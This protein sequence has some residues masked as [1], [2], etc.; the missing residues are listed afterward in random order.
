MKK[1]KKRGGRLIA[2]LVL[3][4]RQTPRRSPQ[5]SKP[6]PGKLGFPQGTGWERRGGGARQKVR[7]PR[8]SGSQSPGRFRREGRGR[9][10]PSGRAQGR[11]LPEH[12]QGR[13][14][15]LPMRSRCG[16]SEAGGRARA[17]PPRWQLREPG[18]GAA[19]GAAAA[20]A[21]RSAR[22]ALRPGPPGWEPRRKL[23]TFLAGKLQSARASLR[24]FGRPQP[25]SVAGAGGEAGS[26][27]GSPGNESEA[28]GKVSGRP[29]P[30]PPPPRTTGAF[31]E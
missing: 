15:A 9:R 3:S 14:L 29:C 17:L 24:A 31:R 2:L 20:T 26:R 5:G 11:C 21:E 12:A 19:A 22:R 10:S 23:E 6:S 27:G 8:P 4:H 25:G 7:V 30:P 28:G 13:G 1:K 16:P 18:S